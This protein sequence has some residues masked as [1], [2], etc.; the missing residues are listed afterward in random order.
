MADDKLPPI[1]RVIVAGPFRVA[2]SLISPRTLARYAG[3]NVGDCAGL[4]C[5]EKSR[6]YIDKTLSLRRQW[7]V[8]WHELTHAVHDLHTIF[9]GGL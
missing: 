2:V 5:P 3:V 8:Y 9:C 1:P 6:V 4:W 7:D